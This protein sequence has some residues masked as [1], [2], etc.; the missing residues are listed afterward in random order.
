MTV[1][2]MLVL[3]LMGKTLFFE[4]LHYQLGLEIICIFLPLEPLYI[5]DNVLIEIQFMCTK[6]FSL[7]THDQDQTSVLILQTA[8]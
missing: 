5:F 4:F 8:L 6:I 1:G 3:V 7:T 2:E